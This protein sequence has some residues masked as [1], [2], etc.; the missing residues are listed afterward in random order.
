[1][2]KM[3]DSTDSVCAFCPS[4]L[5]KNFFFL[6][7]T[8]FLLLFAAFMLLLVLYGYCEVCKF[9]QIFEEAS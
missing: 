1:M 8:E 5:K 6:K 9:L 2:S 7:A 3:A 4:D